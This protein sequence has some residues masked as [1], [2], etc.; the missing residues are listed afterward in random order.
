MNEQTEPATEI[1]RLRESLHVCRNNVRRLKE[2]IELLER[3]MELAGDDPQLLWL[4]RNREERMDPAV[5]VFPPLRAEFH[6]ARYRFACQFASGKSVVDIACGT[7]YGC[8]MMAEEGRARSVTGVDRS[9]EAIAWARQ[10]H[11]AENTN[12]RVADA[13]ATGL[14]PASFDLVTSFETIEHVQDDGALVAEFHR[15]L[16]PGGMLV[17]STPNGW[18]LEIATH[19]VREYDRR[20]FEDVLERHF[21]V[22]QLY[23]QNSGSD[24]QFNH[25]QPAGILPTTAENERLA[26]CYIAVARR[27][28]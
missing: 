18:P 28:E 15:L 23:N 3:A 20:A 5:P 9:P 24:F 25:G 13:T 19:H 2:R 12:W 21:E 26:E 14:E 11:A 10:R 7:G 27:R 1:E 8:Q 16:R 17:C 6:L 22:E 4:Y